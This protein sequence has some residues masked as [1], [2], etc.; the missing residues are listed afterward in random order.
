[1]FAAAS[2]VY[3]QEVMRSCREVYKKNEKK[4]LLGLYLY[5]GGAFIIIAMAA[6]VPTDGTW[7]TERNNIIYYDKNIT[8]L[9]RVRSGEVF[10]V[11][12]EWVLIGSCR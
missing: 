8:R 7:T 9:W 5:R 4:P 12:K 3:R 10:A 11:T 1:M 2:W 6:S